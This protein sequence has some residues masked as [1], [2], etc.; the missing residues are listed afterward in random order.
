MVIGM[1]TEQEDYT[2]EINYD[3]NAVEKGL[4][5]IIPKEGVKEIIL[6]SDALLD[7]IGH[8]IQGRG[9]AITLAE[10]DRQEIW[11]MEVER[12]FNFVAEKD[13]KKGDAIAVNGV[14]P[15]P[16]LLF[17]AEQEF[18]TCKEGKDKTFYAISMDGLTERMKEIAKGNFGIVQHMLGLNGVAPKDEAP[19][20]APESEIQVEKGDL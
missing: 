18:N 7:I 12:Q 2:L 4:I 5:K 1:K 3:D 19:Q 13:Y 14:H 8:R 6:S 9:I 16:V 11:M 15:Y 17:A 20:L 10:I